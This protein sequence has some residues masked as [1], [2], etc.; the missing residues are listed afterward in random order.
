MQRD[1]PGCPGERARRRQADAG[2]PRRMTSVRSGFCGAAPWRMLLGCRKRKPKRH[3]R[4]II[5]G[6]PQLSAV[7]LNSRSANR[8]SY[9][10]AI[11]LGAVKCAEKSIGVLGL[12]ANADVFDHHH[13]LIGLIP[14]CA[15]NEDT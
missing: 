3:P 15:N 14:L 9:A 1:K 2:S 6:S 12:D 10:Q 11:R 5:A 7:R 8:E 13:H 4:A